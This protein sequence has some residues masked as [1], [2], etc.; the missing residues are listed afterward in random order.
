ME[1]GL[2]KKFC[3]ALLVLVSAVGIS[4]AAES[5]RSIP[6]KPSEL[7]D[8]T[9]VWNIHLKSTAEQFKA[10]QPANDKGFFGLGGPRQAQEFGPAMFLLPIFTKAGDVNG[11][12]KISRQEFAEMGARWFAEWD[13][14]K[15]GKITFAQLRNALNTTFAGGGGAQMMQIRLQG[16]EGRRNGLASAMGVEFKY[17]HA[18]L[19]FEGEEFKDVAVRYKG[20][21][22]WLNSM[23]MDKRSMKID[24]NQFNKG[25]KLAGIVTLNLHNNVTDASWMNEVMSHRLYRDAGVAGARSAYARVYLTVPGKFDRK[26]IGLYS[27]VENIDKHFLAENI[28]GKKGALLKPVTPN[29][30]AYL[31][32]DWAKY[33]QIYDPKT[34]LSAKQQKRIIALCKLLDS[35]DQDVFDSK[36]A[37]YI[38]VDE[39][40]RYM[41]VTVWL[42]T[43][44]SI[45]SIGQNYYIYLDQSGKVQFLPWDLDHSFGQFFL[46]GTQEQR[47]KLSINHPWRGDNKFLE[48]MFKVESFKKVYLQHMEDFSKGIFQPERFIKQV[49][50]I[51]AAIRPSVAEESSTRL[52]RFD[53]VVAGK[54]VERN[55]FGAQRGGTT[56]PATQPGT[57]NSPPPLPPPGAFGR[58]SPIKIF[59]PLRTASVL[60][61]LSGKSQ[62]MMLDA[63]P[64]PAPPPP[65]KNAF[66]PGF[67]L[68]PVVMKAFD[69][70]QNQ[71]ITSAEAA[72]G[73]AKWFNSWDTDKSGFLTQE[74]LR[75]GLNQDLSTAT[76]GPFARPPAQPAAAR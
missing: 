65:G 16:D 58:V 12:G 19:E 18:D 31:G 66:G 26:Y 60:E 29:L 7:Y 2:M 49:D 32:N 45:L 67:F 71:E 75:A 9:T 36:I 14:D 47:E 23:G 68:T 30:F 51:A 46:V 44:D 35:A 69:A 13:K 40:A 17:V 55:E 3:Y 25:Q 6:T 33:N 37:D 56:Q 8:T 21:G 57:K 41:A 42:S 73:F 61:Q 28:K 72:A 64:I 11:D 48:R 63:A 74:Q 43:L 39:F 70:D 76:P 10:M 34:E 62:G 50:Q 24:L 5:H 38:D 15:K 20:N 22:T 54:P 4:F 1:N 27:L 52:A 59:A 53:S